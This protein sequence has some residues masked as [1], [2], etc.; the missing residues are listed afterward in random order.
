MATRAQFDWAA[1]KADPQFR[2][3][4]RQRLRF[5]LWLLAGAGVVFFP[6]PILAAWFPEWL[7]IRVSGAVNVGLLLVLAQFVAA[8]SIAWIY[9]WRANRVFDPAAEKIFFLALDRYKKR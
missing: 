9:T 8:G 1:V 5:V 3:Y 4:H 7:A 6:L 2:D